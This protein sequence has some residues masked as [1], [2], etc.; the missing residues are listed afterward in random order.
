MPRRKNAKCL[1]HGK[2]PSM[3]AQD[4]IKCSCKVCEE[5]TTHRRSKKKKKAP[6]AKAID[7]LSS[8]DMCNFPHLGGTTGYRRG[9]R[10]KKCK[11]AKLIPMKD[12]Y[13]KD[14]EKFKEKS[15]KRYQN[16]DNE[17]K[18][19]YR[20]KSFANANPEAKEHE[21][22]YKSLV[23]DSTACEI[24]GTPFKDASKIQIDHDHNTGAI[25][26]ALCVPC[27][28]AEGH[29]KTLANAKSLVNYLE[30]NNTQ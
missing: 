24:C 27:N 11:D 6:S 21:E 5:Y 15:R 9:C 16:L 2:G 14:P 23:R 19:D 8:H 18:L 4:K 12:L 17:G 30:R 28:Q 20:W 13:R 26:G 22:R 3:V 29:I 7:G 1:V 25:R 10:C